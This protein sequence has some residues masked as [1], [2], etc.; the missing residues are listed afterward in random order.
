MLILIQLT[1]E[2]KG[3]LLNVNFTPNVIISWIAGL[4]YNT[5]EL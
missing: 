3:I 5:R 1:V 2:L 4:L